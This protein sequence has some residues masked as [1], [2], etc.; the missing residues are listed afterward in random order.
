MRPDIQLFNLLSILVFLVIIVVLF[1]FLILRRSNEKKKLEH[2]VQ[3][4]TNEL[5]I[6]L[7]GLETALENSKAISKSKSLFHARMS[8][9]LQAPL[10]NI[11]GFSELALDDDIVQKT[12]DYLTNIRANADWMLQIINDIMDISKIES[13]EMSLKKVPFDLHELFASCRTLIM[14]KA[15]EK[16][17]L[18]HFYAEPSVGKKPVGDPV[19]LRQIFVNLL[20]NAVKFT[21]TGMIKLVSDIISIDDKSITIHFEIKDSGIG[22]TSEQVAVIF[23]PFSQLEIT[24]RKYGGTGLGLPITKNIIEMMGGKLYID[25]TP[26]VG[27]RFSFDL[28]FDTIDGTI[29]DM[30]QHKNILKDVEKPL[31]EGEVLICED[32]FMKQ[33]VIREHLSKV[34]L[35]TEIVGNGLLGVEM[36]KRRVN[37]SEKLFDLILMDMHM[38]VMDGLEAAIEIVKLGVK[39][40]I[41]ALTANIMTDEIETYKKHGI[42]DWVGKPFTSQELWRCLIKYLKP[43]NTLESQKRIHGEANLDSD[44]EFKKSLEKYFVKTNINKYEEICKFIEEGDIKQA[45][46]LVH[47]LRGNAGQIGK[48]DLQSAANVVEHQLTDGTN[49]ATPEQMIELKKELDSVL[50]EFMPLL[51]ENI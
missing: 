21:N 26:G 35:K 33:E 4:R 38:P 20:S 5:D 44:I 40:P 31:F 49:T 6:R 1:I 24:T 30:F 50:T 45:H 23:D 42:T 34:G 22:M 17:I 32:D 41:I 11:I 9:E 28:T 29:D 39:I 37:K 13:G 18:L 15:V 7:Q 3:V 43:L 12:R 51:N 19:R 47:A 27:S 2:L 46:R 36:I 16:G 48:N 8:D 25:S 14:P 10:S